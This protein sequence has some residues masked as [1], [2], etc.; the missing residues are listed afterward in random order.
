MQEKPSGKKNRLTACVFLGFLFLLFSFNALI[1]APLGS[2]S[3]IA[4]D[5][6]DGAEPGG[7]TWYTL[8]KDDYRIAGHLADVDVSDSTFRFL[9]ERYS[10]Y[11][12]IVNMPDGTKTA[13][14]VCVKGKKAETIADGNLVDLYGTLSEPRESVALAMAGF[15]PDADELGPFC[16]NDDGTTVLARWASSAIFSAMSVVTIVLFVRIIKRKET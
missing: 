9:S 15:A 2:V 12:A 1:H 8:D 7:E 10:Y 5:G 14:P 6:L 11:C 3:D 4:A 13:I 16:L